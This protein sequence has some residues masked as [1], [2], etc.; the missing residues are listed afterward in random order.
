[1]VTVIFE[2]LPFVAGG[3]DPMKNLEPSSNAK[4]K[5]RPPSDFFLNLNIKMCVYGRLTDLRF[6]KIQ[7]NYFLL[8]ILRQLQAA[9]TPALP[10][11]HTRRSTI[12][13][14]DRKCPKSFSSTCVRR[15]LTM[16]DDNIIVA[17]SLQ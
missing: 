16:T 17:R 8:Q 4:G 15:R 2:T 12:Y 14:T 7:G 6:K 3:V 10:F 11:T 13:F 5:S 1:M 9:K